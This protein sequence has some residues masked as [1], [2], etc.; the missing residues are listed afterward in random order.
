MKDTQFGLNRQS[1]IDMFEKHELN[2][3]GLVEKSGGSPL[4]KTVNTVYYFIDEK[5]YS[6]AAGDM[7]ALSTTITTL[8][9]NVFVFSVDSAG[10]VTTSAG[11]QAAALEDVVFP[12]VP[13]N[14]SVLG[15]LILYNGS[16]SDFVGGTTA[17]N[18]GGV[19]DTYIEALFPMRFA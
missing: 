8:Y 13:A 10:T 2:S 3:G 16:G 1:L 15:F 14:N 4:V 9:Y 6:L 19:T 17:L 11:T 18:T 5:L 12:A 7:A